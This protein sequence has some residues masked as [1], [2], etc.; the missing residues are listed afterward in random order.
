MDPSTIMGKWWE[1]A[2]KRAREE[3]GLSL[4]DA[5]DAMRFPPNATPLP[6]A[7]PIGQGG[8][9]LPG[10]AP[11]G[12][13]GIG[14]DA[15]FSIA[16]NGKPTVDEATRKAKEQNR[17]SREQALLGAYGATTTAMEAR[18]AV[19][20][21]LATLANDHISIDSARAETL[22]RL[23]VEQ[24]LGITAMKASADAARVEADTI[25]MSVGAAAEC[26]AVQTKLNEARRNGVV[27]SPE[28][29][30]A[31]RREAAALGEATQHADMMKWSYT[32]LVQGP[33]QTFRSS[34]A[35]GAKGFDALKAAGV[36][37]LNAISTKLMDMA[38]QNLWQAAMGGKSGSGGLFGLLGGLFGGGSSGGAATFNLG[39]SAGAIFAK[40]GV[41]S[42]SSDISRYSN[43]IVTKPTFFAKGGN[44]MGEAGPEAVM[45]LVRTPGGNLG[46]RATGTGGASQAPVNVY[47]TQHNTFTGADPGSEARL[48]GALEKTK[49]E[50]VSEATQAVAKVYASNSSYLKGRT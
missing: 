9:P 10:A 37:A 21:Q 24:N 43:Q 32:N 8:I 12:Q 50:A 42:A 26:V 28:H 40:G 41:P 17:I 45:P 11:I 31:I 49:R 1:E 2:K 35:S 30:D 39:G 3:P 48:R 6:G 16:P 29:V 18:R 14:G 22:K 36:S 23:A 20:L 27:I 4:S 5:P 15:R 33:L 44:V 7:A 19:E 38:A 46:V 47:L 25:G 34:L 13:G